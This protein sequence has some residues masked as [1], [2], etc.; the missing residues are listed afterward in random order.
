MEEKAQREW[1]WKQPQKSS[2][3]HS[4]A[5]QP[6]RKQPQLLGGKSTLLA[7]GLGRDWISCFA[8]GRRVK[9]VNIDEVRDFAEQNPPVL[10]R[11][12]DKSPE[13]E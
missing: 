8:V 12:V 6:L 2:I 1:L 5:G 3:T 10:R 7:I 11:S 13:V 4:K 9:L